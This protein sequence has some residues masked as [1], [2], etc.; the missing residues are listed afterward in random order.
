MCKG[1]EWVYVEEGEVLQASS[2]ACRDS[3]MCCPGSGLH[4]HILVKLRTHCGHVG[5]PWGPPSPSPSPPHAY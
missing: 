5:C 3:A 2:T 4:P 1:F